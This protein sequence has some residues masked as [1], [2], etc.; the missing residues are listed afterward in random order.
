LRGLLLLSAGSAATAPAAA[1]AAGSLFATACCCVS[2]RFGLRRQMYL[3]WL[4]ARLQQQRARPPQGH[5]HQ[6]V[7]QTCWGETGPPTLQKG[8]RYHCSCAGWQ[9]DAS[10]LMRRRT[11][12]LRKC[13]G[14]SWSGFSLPRASRVCHRPRNCS[15]NVHSSS[16]PLHSAAARQQLSS[17]RSQLTWAARRRLPCIAA[18]LAHVRL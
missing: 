11:A 1:A 2:F 5:S 16:P 17:T 9:T 15:H 6:H 10:S 7:V 4:V 14:S 18:P 12:H 8:P 3:L 13:L